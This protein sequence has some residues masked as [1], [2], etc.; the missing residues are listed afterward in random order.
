MWHS[1]NMHVSAF[2]C[3]TAASV[4]T[5]RAITEY[6]AEPELG[7]LGSAPLLAEVA[8]AKEVVGDNNRPFTPKTLFRES[9]VLCARRGVNAA[10]SAFKSKGKLDLTVVTIITIV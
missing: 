5:T 1:M 6:I 8:H 10:E 9:A 2:P 4:C 7:E 3:S